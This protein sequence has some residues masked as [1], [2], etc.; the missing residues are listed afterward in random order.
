MAYFDHQRKTHTYLRINDTL[1]HLTFIKSWW[2]LQCFK[3]MHVCRYP[4]VLVTA[5]TIGFVRSFVRSF[6]FLLPLAQVAC[7]LLRGTRMHAP[8]QP[9][10]QGSLLL[11][12]P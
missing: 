5:Y 6:G 12:A 8:D 3:R 9:C 11:V 10:S 4:L 1:S 2:F 7:L